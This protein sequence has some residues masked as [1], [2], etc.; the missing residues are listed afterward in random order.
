MHTWLAAR[1]AHAPSFFSSLSLG[2]PSREK[3]ER[4]ENCRRGRNLIREHAP[5]LWGNHRWGCYHPL[6]PV[7]L[8]I[9]DLS[10]SLSL[11]LSL[12]FRS[13]VKRLKYISHRESCTQKF[14]LQYVINLCA[15]G[16]LAEIFYD[17]E[18]SDELWGGREG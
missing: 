4:D 12:S 13:D 16:I 2:H 10:L 8:L 17:R 9:R 6:L 18:R 1:A 3:P 14:M 5:R 11:F 7:L 15:F